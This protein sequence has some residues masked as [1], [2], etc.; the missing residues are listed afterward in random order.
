MKTKEK[1][2]GEL[3][4]V[5]EI[6]YDRL[7]V[8][9]LTFTERRGGYI[10]GKACVEVQAKKR[11]GGGNLLKNPDQQP[12]DTILEFLCMKSDDPVEVK[13]VDVSL[14]TLSHPIQS[15]A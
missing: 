2:Y 9:E 7:N 10:F 5:K 14:V 3:K 11:G 8:A 6:Q 4:R 13:L 1:W 12:T 15:D